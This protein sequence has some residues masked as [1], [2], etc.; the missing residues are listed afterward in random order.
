MTA[1]GVAPAREVVPVVA[2]VCSRPCPAG[3]SFLGFQ[4]G[5]HHGLHTWRGMLPSQRSGLT[6]WGGGRR[7]GVGGG[8]GGG[9]GGV[10]H[11]RQ[12]T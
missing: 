12:A 11:R 5:I 10:R 6:L 4:G 7:G 8:G 3:S 2:N 9:G 1:G